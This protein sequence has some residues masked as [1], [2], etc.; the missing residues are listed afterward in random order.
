[1]AGVAGAAWAGEGMTSSVKVQRADGT[2]PF[3]EITQVGRW[4]YSL[5]GVIDDISIWTRMTGD[6]VWG[7]RRAER[8]ALKRLAQYRRDQQRRRDV[9][10][11]SEAG[12]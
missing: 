8:R 9:T 6:R 2:G 7:R 12:A 10:V 1:M 5:S 11:V 4:T 3:V